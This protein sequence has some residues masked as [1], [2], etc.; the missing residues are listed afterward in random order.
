LAVVAISRVA[1]V[2]A[3]SS[4]RF[5]GSGELCSGYG[6]WRRGARGVTGRST[7]RRN[8]APNHL[9]LTVAKTKQKQTALLAP[10]TKPLA[11]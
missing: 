6:G 8:K 4:R 5:I 11:P 2:R 10:N 3:R 1:A 9:A 7:Q